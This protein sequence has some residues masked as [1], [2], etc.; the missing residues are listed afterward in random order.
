MNN[1]SLQQQRDIHKPINGKQRLFQQ[2]KEK[3]WCKT[4]HCRCYEERNRWCWKTTGFQPRLFMTSNI[5]V[6]AITRRYALQRMLSEFYFGF[7]MHTFLLFIAYTMYESLQHVGINPLAKNSLWMFGSAIILR[8]L[9]KHVL[10][11]HIHLNKQWI[12]AMARLSLKT[13]RKQK[14]V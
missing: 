3:K 1:D 11:W 13:K 7:N 2:M 5:T 8:V 9:Y 14:T 10:S 12:Y 6:N 4:L